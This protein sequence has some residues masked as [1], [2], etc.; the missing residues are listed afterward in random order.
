MTCLP[1]V[2]LFFFIPNIKPGLEQ[3][4]NK[5]TKPS[6]PAKLVLSVWVIWCRNLIKFCAYSGTVS[7]P[8]VAAASASVSS[9]NLH[10]W[11]Y[12]SQSRDKIRD[13][14][15][16]LR[17]TREKQKKNSE[18]LN[19]RILL[20]TNYMQGNYQDMTSSLWSL[21]LL[22]VH[23]LFWNRRRNSSQTQHHMT[24]Q[25]TINIPT[26]LEKITLR[27]ESALLAKYVCRY[28]EYDSDSYHCC[29]CTYTRTHITAQ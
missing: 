6:C 11:H 1:W 12:L 28:K 15:L 9:D 27:T 26:A 17:A 29:Q 22:W 25:I 14:R 19:N 5:R 10:H 4:L 8:D 21:R 18:N 20:I 16:S 2:W 24:A 7:F 13:W 23:Q 3:K